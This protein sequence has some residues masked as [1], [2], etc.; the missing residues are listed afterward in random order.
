MSGQAISG[1]RLSRISGTAVAISSGTAAGLSGTTITLSAQ[2]QVDLTASG[3]GGLD[4]GNRKANATYAIWVFTPS[5]G[6]TE[7]IASLSFTNPSLPSGATDSRRVGVVVTRT[8]KSIPEFSQAGTSNTRDYTWNNTASERTVGAQLSATAWTQDSLDQWVPPV[9]TQ[10]A[11]S[12][13]VTT[14][15]GQVRAK[16]STTSVTVTSQQTSTFIPVNDEGWYE[17]RTTGTALLTVIV[18]GW[19]DEL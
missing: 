19:R 10:F 18:T 1:M 16:G 12:L 13:S 8:D 17:F 7:G 6:G 9:A 3:A 5:S 4:T 14:P 15:Q 11:L 2:A